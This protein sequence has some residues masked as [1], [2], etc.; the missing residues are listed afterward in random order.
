M[1]HRNKTKKTITKNYKQTRRQSRQRNQKTA[2]IL[3]HLFALYEEGSRFAWN[4]KKTH[5]FQPKSSLSNAKDSHLS[6]ANYFPEAIVSFIK[7]TPGVHI[8]YTF[9]NVLGREKISLHFW[10]Y[11]KGLGQAFLS[12]YNSYVEKILAWLHIITKNGAGR[13]RNRHLDFYFYLTPFKK[14]LPAT[15]DEVLGAHHIN[16]GF[17]RPC[18]DD[19]VIVIYRKEEWF[20]VFLHE[21]IHHFSVDFS[22]MDQSAVNKRIGGI[23]D[24][25]SE[26]NLFE[27][28][29]EWWAEMYNLVF[30][31]KKPSVINLSKRLDKEVAHGFT[32]MCK[33]LKHMGLTYRDLFF[34]NP[35]SKLL[36]QKKYREKTNVL[37]YYVIHQILLHYWQDFLVWCNMHNRRREDLSV[38][39][40]PHTNAA[41]MSFV[42]FIEAHYDA[43]DF[44][45]CV[46]KEEKKVTRV[47]RTAYSSSSLATT[48]SLRMTLWD[49]DS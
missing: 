45:H 38:F 32:Q 2:P 9:E 22:S 29:T 17:T 19:G 37:A 46:N 44:M 13:C 15:T 34:K 28:Y 39:E 47:A 21:T 14:E 30:A 48:K 40:I 43:A 33:V 26:V 27:A 12:T 16:T 23:F 42:D 18:P 7:K 3:R 36:R 11:E 41:L 49:Q 25:P 20:K 35:E 4:Y 31:L 10:D 6:A 24:V 1:I 5:G 8:M